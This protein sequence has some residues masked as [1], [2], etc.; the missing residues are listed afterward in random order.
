MHH[1]KHFRRLNRTI[2]HRKSLFRNL[3]TQL[4][5]YDRIKTTLPKAQELKAIAD[6][7]QEPRQ[8]QC[9]FSLLF[10]I[11]FARYPLSTLDREPRQPI[12]SL[13][14]VSLLFWI[15]LAPLFHLLDDHL[16]KAWRLACQSSGCLLPQSTFFFFFCSVLRPRPRLRKRMGELWR[17]LQNKSFVFHDLTQ[18][19]THKT[20]IAFPFS[21]VSLSLS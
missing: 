16:W 10:G 6:Q 14:S 17:I 2:S 9:S 15:Q 5:Q 19:E 3:V 21:V 11:D 13:T 1:G 4:I 8:E 20:I 12:V 18:R 7:V